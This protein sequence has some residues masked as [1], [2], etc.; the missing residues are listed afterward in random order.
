MKHWKKLSGFLIFMGTSPIF[1]NDTGGAV[2][3]ALSSIQKN[4][5]FIWL[6]MAAGMVFIMQAGFMCLESG[7]ARAKNSINVAVKNFADFV[8]ASIGFWV[9]GFG[10]MFGESVFGI[11]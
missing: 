7:M 1:A 3:K 2:N 11:F 5:D 9:I 8:I 6:L 4:V 10:L